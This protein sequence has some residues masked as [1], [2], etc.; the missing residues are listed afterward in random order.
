MIILNFEKKKKI[1]DFTHVSG[2]IA[3]F[4]RSEFSVSLFSED[5]SV[6]VFRSVSPH[7]VCKFLKRHRLK[8]RMEWA[9]MK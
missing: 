5:H 7:P 6:S 3:N 9:G 1:G 2:E 4:V 8:Q